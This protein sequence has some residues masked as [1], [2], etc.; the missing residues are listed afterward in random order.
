QALA[1]AA[2]LPVL[3]LNY[4]SRFGSP[5]RRFD[6]SKRI[7]I[8]RPMR[9][10]QP[11]TTC[12][13][14]PIPLQVDHAFLNRCPR[15]CAPSRPFWCDVQTAFA[16]FRVMQLQLKILPEPDRDR[17]ST[18]LNSSHVSISYAVFC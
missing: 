12:L 5:V 13:L 10:R 18:R 15:L 11:V 7:E 1:A 6:Q 3:R 2:S 8:I 14:E 16:T 4:P 17:K 9:R